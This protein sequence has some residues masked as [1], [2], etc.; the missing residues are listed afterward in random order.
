MTM[1]K[2][3]ILVSGQS[4]LGKTR[5]A[6]NLVDPQRM[7]WISTEVDGDTTAVRGRCQPPWR[8]DLALRGDCVTKIVDILNRIKDV[9]G[10]PQLDG[11][12][13]DLVVIDSL[14]GVQAAVKYE[15]IK[16][17]RRMDQKSWGDLKDA[18]W[19]L[20]RAINNTPVTIVGIVH[21]EI[22]TDQL[23]QKLR[24]SLTIE[25]GFRSQIQAACSVHAIV[26]PGADPNNRYLVTKPILSNG[27]LYDGKDRHGIFG[28]GSVKITGDDGYPPLSVTQ[29]FTSYLKGE[30]I[31]IASESP[32]EGQVPN[33]EG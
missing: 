32:D 30:T 20:L 5:L 14:D 28:S 10:Q 33:D 13:I 8:V 29:I 31:Q 7:L 16:G 21:S 6:A 22:R 2:T 1:H 3:F 12:P 15:S 19:P 27:V 24:A 25:G 18:M 9:N 17:D 26:V 4:G 23:T 11:K